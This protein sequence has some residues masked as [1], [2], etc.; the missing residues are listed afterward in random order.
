MAGLVAHQY[1]V[2]EA[3]PSRRVWIGDE[4]GSG[5]CTKPRGA[6]QVLRWWEEIKGNLTFTSS[7][8][9]WFV[10]VCVWILWPPHVKS[11]LIGKDPDA[12]RDWGQEEKGTTEDEMAGWDCRLNGHEFEWTRELVMDREAW[13]AVIHGVA[14]SRKRLSDW[15]EL[16]WTDDIS[17]LEKFPLPLHKRI[18]IWT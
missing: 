3:Q 4:I 8:L 1:T 13:C 7:F 18:P 17:P 6:E 2:P 9:L 5:E 12:G 15:T 14:K 10:C 16:N 11:W